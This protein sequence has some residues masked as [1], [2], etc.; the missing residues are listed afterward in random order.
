MFYSFGVAL[1]NA[2]GLHKHSAA[3]CNKISTLAKKHN[4]IEKNT[5]NCYTDAFY[6]EPENIFK[7]LF[8]KHLFFF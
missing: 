8:T 4:W 5:F 3:K 1:Y 6:N 7:N 2:Y